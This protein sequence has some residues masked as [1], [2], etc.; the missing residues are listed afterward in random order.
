MNGAAESDFWDFQAEEPGEMSLDELRDER[1]VVETKKAEAQLR[2]AREREN[3]F[4]E[5][6]KIDKYEKQISAY[7]SRLAQIKEEIAKRG[8]VG[9]NP[10]KAL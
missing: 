9:L 7:E 8:G 2:L 1:R 10:T 6:F 3:G 5:V 4:P